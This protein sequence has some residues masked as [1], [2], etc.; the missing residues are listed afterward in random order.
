MRL[1][2]TEQT[3]ARA[4]SAVEEQARHLTTLTA[5]VGWLERVVNNLV[6]S[7][8]KQSRGIDRMGAESTAQR[9]TINN[10]IKLATA[11]LEQR[12]SYLDNAYHN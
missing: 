5:N 7:I 2:K 12:A 9:E 8:G 1:D 3:V 10:L 11:A 6:A 4:A